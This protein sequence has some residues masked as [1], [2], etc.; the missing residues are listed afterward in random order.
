MDDDL[1]KAVHKTEA[2]MQEAHPQARANF[3]LLTLSNP[4]YF[5]NLIESPF[6]PVLPICCN[7]HYESLGCVG[8]QPQQ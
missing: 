3:K 8:Y 4:N 6:K 7:T 2:A 5:G 1:K